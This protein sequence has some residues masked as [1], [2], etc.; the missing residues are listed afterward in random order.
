MANNA[1]EEASD[2]LVSLWRA[3][4][5][6]RELAEK[7][8]LL[9]VSGDSLKKPKHVDVNPTYLQLANA[10][11]LD[12]PIITAVVVVAVLQTLNIIG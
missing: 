3:K 6:K 1:A 10:T 8:A 11:L 2:V 7:R 4:V 12:A 5:S 9:A